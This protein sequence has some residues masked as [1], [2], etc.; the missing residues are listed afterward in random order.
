MKDFRTFVNLKKQIYFL[1][2]HLFFLPVPDVIKVRNLSAS[3]LF[4]FSVSLFSEVSEPIRFQWK[5]ETG[6]ILELNEYHDV[7]FRV[8][9][10]SLAREDRNR[11]LLKTTKCDATSCQVG[12]SFDTYIR[13]GKTT[14]PFQK[15][16]NFESSFTIRRNGKY[17]VPDE[18]IMP[19]LRSFPT[20]PEASVHVGDSWKLPA[21]E[22]FDFSGERIRIPVEP[23][24]VYLGK[25]NWKFQNHSGFADKISYT[26]PIFFDRV[27]RKN[28]RSNAPVK[29]FGFARGMVYFNSTKGLP[30]FK[31]VKLSYTFILPDGTVQEASYD[32]QGIYESR[33]GLNTVEKEKF[34][35][36]VL[37]DLIVD[38]LSKP[39]PLH[40]DQKNESPI[41]VRTSED[42]VTFSLDSIL[43][44]F[45]D[46]KL[47]PEAEEAIKRISE[48]LKKHPDREIRVAGHTDNIGKKEYN[49]K[50]S[51][52]RAKSV[53]HELVTSHKMNEGKISFKGYGDTSPITTN[54]NEENRAKNRRVEITLVLD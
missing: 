29:I 46:S 37:K 47:K 8:G 10:R 17:E 50:L 31:T 3:I 42:G 20:F 11:I 43:F 34:T 22:S 18:Y 25:E 49:Q 28:N 53:L 19:N 32:I 51:E 27:D 40:L 36:D 5:W 9:N 33:R 2:G 4:L 16:K 41:S 15:D 45:N 26:Y 24:Y 54:D 7:L 23:E 52:D 14:G 39:N 12:A 21:E 44:D 38:D 30:E 6:Q 35:E 1:L 48:I 13:F